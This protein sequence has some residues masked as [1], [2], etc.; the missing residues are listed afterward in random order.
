MIVYHN[1]KITTRGIRR[2][3]SKVDD[4]SLVYDLFYLIRA[5]MLALGY[6]R[7]TLLK[8]LD[9]FIL[10]MEEVLN[11]RQPFTKADLKINGHDLMALGISPSPILGKILDTL[12]QEVIENPE[13]NTKLQLLKRAMEL[14]VAEFSVGCGQF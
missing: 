5:D 12:L 4:I 9:R 1:M 2:F 14:L 3:L 10:K 11:A 7:P 13:L 6:Y 8:T